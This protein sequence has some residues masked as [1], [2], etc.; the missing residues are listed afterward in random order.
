[1]G[2]RT[3]SVG[4]GR[5]CSNYSPGTASEEK[6]VNLVFTY[7]AESKTTSVDFL[8]DLEEHILDH[9][10]AESLECAQDSSLHIYKL[11]YPD[12]SQASEASESYIWQV[13]YPMFLH[14]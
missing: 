9:A 5:Q 8:T 3:N 7:I 10:A 13:N 6:D 2:D 1:M 14:F 12:D 11:Q 4:Y